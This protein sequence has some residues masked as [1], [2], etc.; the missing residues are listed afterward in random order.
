MEK[1]ATVNVTPLQE[2][3][4]ERID[5]AAA[6]AADAFI[7]SPGYCYIFEGLSVAQ[8]RRALK[9]LFVKNFTVRHGSGVARCAFAEDGEMACFF[10]IQT[11]ESGDVGA[12]TML[13]HGILEIIPRFGFTALLRLL[14][15]KRYHEEVA[16]EFI[17]DQQQQQQQQQQG[18][19]EAEQWCSLERMV[20]HPRWQGRGVGST[21]LGAALEEVTA[22]GWGVLLSTQER[23][24]V[25]F[26]ERLGFSVALR[27]VRRGGVDNRL[28]AKRAPGKKEG[29]EETAP[30][31]CSDAFILARKQESE[32][33]AAAASERIIAVF[34]CFATVAFVVLPL[35]AVALAIAAFNYA[36]TCSP[37]TEWELARDRAAKEGVFKEFTRAASNQ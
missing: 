34:W 37:A 11:P 6:L 36:G 20:V 22:K 28:M 8:R 7:R 25:T 3:P 21:C 31:A 1:A 10:M 17:A 13:R 32:R 27:E 29:K 2:L 26:Y 24:N 35:V 16:R 23:R 4:Y 19:E 5:E 14:E 33:V 9:W 12:W 15:V 30:V 18:T